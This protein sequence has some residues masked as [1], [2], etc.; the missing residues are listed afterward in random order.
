V[1]SWCKGSFAPDMCL[2]EVRGGRLPWGGCRVAAALG[3]QGLGLLTAAASTPSLD[4]VFDSAR[5]LHM[6]LQLAPPH[7]AP[8]RVASPDG[9]YVG[10][11]P[12]PPPLWMAPQ[13]PLIQRP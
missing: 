3:C 10:L 1:C 5:R 9:Y 8:T 7:C 4:A 12:W 13:T 6:Q 11:Q 2:D